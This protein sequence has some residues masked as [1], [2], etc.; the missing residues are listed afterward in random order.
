MIERR[1]GRIVA[2]SSMAGRMGN[3]NLAHYVAAKWG[4]IGLV[5]T[6][7]L[8]V[9]EHGITVNVVCPATTD[10]PAARALSS[11]AQIPATNWRASAR[12]K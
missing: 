11:S 2:T 9:A 12:S 8:E 1:Y 5:K 4:V 10:T 7:A 6:I 3:R